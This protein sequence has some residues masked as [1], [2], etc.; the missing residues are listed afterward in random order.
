[1]WSVEYFSEGIGLLWLTIGVLAVLV[2]LGVVVRFSRM[3][4]YLGNILVSC[5]L[6]A[7]SL[8]FWVFTF[9]FPQEQAGP[10]VI[11]RLYI[12]LILLL[13]GV[14]LVRTFRGEEDAVP[15]VKQPRLTA[16]VMVA[17]I[18][19]FLVMPF[20]GYFLSSFLFVVVL[21]HMLSYPKKG[22]I[23]AIAAGW[24]VFSYFAFYKLLYVQLPL[25]V[26]E[27]LF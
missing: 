17:L 3:R 12:F 13:S 9:E 23:Y 1:M 27:G 24:V 15:G 18:V 4:P 26:F 8:V 19:Y 10:A 16:G 7:V 5:T 2:G 25:G 6:M 21:L 20:L 22:L 14:V 11:P